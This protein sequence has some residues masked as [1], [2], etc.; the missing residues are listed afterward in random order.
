MMDRTLSLGLG[1]LL[2]IGFV[3]PAKAAQ[4]RVWEGTITIPTYLL[5]PQDPNPPFPLVNN[6]NIYPYTVLDDLTDKRE[7]VTYPAIYL[8]NEYLK[9]T[10]LPSMD[11]RVYSLYDKV[12]KREVFYRN[13]V[14]KY[15]LVGLRGAWISGGIEFNFPNGHTTDTV[16]PV[17]S[18][19]RQNPDGSVTAIV[20]DTDQVSNMYWE[21]ALTLRPGVARLEQNVTLFNSTPLPQL[22]WWWANAAVPAT[23]DMQFIYPM[24]ETNP[25][26]HEEIW[27]FPVWQGVNYSWYKDV[28]HATSL[29]G[30]DVHRNFFGAYYHNTD[31]G[32]IHVADYHKVYGKKTWTWGTAPSGMIWAHLL[33]DNDGQYNEIQSGR[34]QTQLSQEFISPHT[35]EN[36][37]EYW[38]PVSKLG[39]GFVEGTPEFA[40][41]VLFQG[42]QGSGKPA[43]EIA[44]NPTVAMRG[45]KVVVK[46]GSQPLKDFGPVTFEPLVT[47]KFSV[48]VD[49]LETAKKELDVTIEN[50]EGKSLLHWFAGAPI[51]GNPNFVPQAGSHKVTAKS[52]NELSVEDLFLRGET[53]EKEGRKANATRIY[54]EVLDR[55]PNYIP[56]LL[57]L[58][59]QACLA[60]DFP[61]AEGLIVRALARDAK[62][63]Q[64]QY[65]AGVIYKGAGKLPLAQDAFWNAI[66]FDGSKA[67]ALA[68]LGEISIKQK[69]YTGAEK[70]LRSALDHNPDD[71]VALSDLA[72]ALRLAGN[73]H[74]ASKIADQAAGKMRVLPYA[75]AERWRID[76]ALDANSS[77]TAQAAHE[78]RRAVGFRSQSYLEAGTW[79]RELGDLESSDFVLQAATRNLKSSEVSPLVYYYLA[80]NA[81]DQGKADQGASYVSEAAKAN[82]EAVF[83]DRPS[84]VEVLRAVLAHDQSDVHAQY[85]LGTFLFAHG[86]YDDAAQL[87]RQA[88][89]GGLQYSVL[90]RNLG[91]YARNVK[92]DL[93]SAA[94]YYAKAVEQNPQDFR[95][96]VNLDEIYAQLG[97]TVARQK[98]LAGAPADVRNRD[99][100][101]ARAVLLNVQTRQYD[102]ALEALSGHH[103]KPSEGGLFIRQLF[104]LANLE[105]GRDAFAAHQY[106]VAEA[107]F[108]AALTYPENLGV[109][110]PDKPHDEE[111]LY[112]LG[113]T[114]QA[115]GKADQ[116]QAAWRQAA[117]EG[118]SPDRGAEERGGSSA[119]F[120]AAAA[121]DQLGKSDEAAHIFDRLA[122]GVADG[123]AGAFD[124]YLAGLVEDYRQRNG[125]AVAD[126]RRA[127]EIDPNLW[128]ARLEVERGRTSGN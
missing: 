7:P 11:G 102:K 24:R 33:T 78:W 73:L 76:A 34:F 93:K 22:Y 71:T 112:W 50:A 66:R 35:V 87:W 47:Q 28:P 45:A 32:V 1:L 61:G 51:D 99:M 108:R 123:H 18:R 107:A 103:F 117:E 125:Q 13:N 31:D 58:A 120:Y 46:L 54:H 27:T 77:A 37:T 109:G 111:A 6:R 124:Y 2:G 65:L 39:G 95:L 40:L 41:N 21:V 42:E 23:E 53:D 85:Y 36:W 127:L 118:S 84:E 98:L 113:K 16:S 9:A 88:A 38:Y 63:P 49:D 3:Q 128:Q 8:E 74:E 19:I 57:K 86:H 104:V 10:I 114:L 91:V 82:P 72:V 67:S 106:Q 70:L 80:A 92:N 116:A 115:E 101:R 119:G 121:L 14:V 68:Q 4:A 43:A 59:Q 25:H 44:V 55:D 110:K 90:Y 96:Y 69:D 48:P 56:A 79:Y 62:D 29:F 52:D 60:A 83:P 15:G 64:A 94:E 17:S 89:D 81:W 12:A 5:G 105:K 75:L 122:N 26:S 100:M 20:G 30:R 97:D 126:F